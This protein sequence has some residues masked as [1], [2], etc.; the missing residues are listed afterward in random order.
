MITSRLSSVVEKEPASSL[1]PLLQAVSQVSAR[2]V[3]Q[4]LT[5]NHL[6]VDQR[7]VPVASFSESLGHAKLPSELAKS[8]VRS[9]QT[10]GGNKPMLIPDISLLFRVQ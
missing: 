7:L 8:V 5:A 3:S 6:N 2:Q 9:I 4:A 10:V 1:P